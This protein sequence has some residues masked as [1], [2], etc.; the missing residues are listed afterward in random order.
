MGRGEGILCEI[1]LERLLARAIHTG[2]GAF[3]V[4][5]NECKGLPR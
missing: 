5:W 1:R 3:K 2:H 4:A